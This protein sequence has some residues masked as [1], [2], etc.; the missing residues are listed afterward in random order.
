MGDRWVDVFLTKPDTYLDESYMYDD[1][2]LCSVQTV[3]LHANSNSAAIVAYPTPYLMPTWSWGYD[4]STLGNNKLR[5]VEVGDIIRVGNPSTG[6]TNYLTVVEVITVSRIYNCLGSDYTTVALSP[7]PVGETSTSVLG[8]PSVNSAW[9]MQLAKTS[10]GT[11]ANGQYPNSAVDFSLTGGTAMSVDAMDLGTDTAPSATANYMQLGTSGIA[12]I[13]L[14][15]NTTLEVTTLPAFFAAMSG[16]TT[17]ARGLIKYTTVQDGMIRRPFAKMHGTTAHSNTMVVRAND[18]TNDYDKTVSMDDE[19]LPYPLYLNKRWSYKSTLQA[20]LNFSIKCI[21]MI[22]LVGYSIVNKRQVG[23][24][25][26][27]EMINDDYFVLNIRE[28]EGKVISNNVHT[29]G[30][31][32]ILHCPLG[33]RSEGTV[34]HSI[35][36]PNGIVNHYFDN[37]DSSVRTLTVS[38]TDRQGNPA[39][40]GRL[41]LWF[42]LL[43]QHG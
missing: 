25:N 40:I 13:V 42:K 22:K 30:A 1:E 24:N 2:F 21:S 35:F 23:V 33:D 41:H 31:F 15:V 5:N 37:P 12:H 28:L 14:R 8:T 39:H 38:I 29:H 6:T 18:G 16:N 17:A 19:R 32:A 3:Q 26:Q 7:V 20:N 4:Q 9:Y 43:T 10:Q 36:E 27:H 34:E 11:A